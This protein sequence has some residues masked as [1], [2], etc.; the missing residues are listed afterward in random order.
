MIVV[1][2]VA[3]AVVVVALYNAQVNVAEAK[4]TKHDI[5]VSAGATKT[6]E[7]CSKTKFWLGKRRRRLLYTAT[8]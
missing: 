4:A 2:V 8:S 7:E 3:A 5:V 6:S 1:V